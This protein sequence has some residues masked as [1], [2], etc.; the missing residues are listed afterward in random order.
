[1]C[2]AFSQGASLEAVVVVVSQGPSGKQ[3]HIM[4]NVLSSF[5]AARACIQK[6]LFCDRP[7]TAVADFGLAL[8]L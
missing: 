3:Q 1:V 7:S 8:G 5:K 6:V 4:S 2:K